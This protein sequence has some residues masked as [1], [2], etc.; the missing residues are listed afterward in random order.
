MKLFAGL[1]TFLG[2]FI[3]ILITMTLKEDTTSIQYMYKMGII[4]GSGMTLSIVGGV[5]TFFGKYLNKKT[6]F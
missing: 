2:I 3:V 1:L 6:N 5:L 4:M